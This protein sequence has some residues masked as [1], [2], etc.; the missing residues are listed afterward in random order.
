[1]KSKYILPIVLLLFNCASSQFYH[2]TQGK[3]D[4][5]NSGQVTYTLPIALPASIQSVGPTINITYSSGQPSGIAGPGWNISTI[6]SIARIST[7]KDIDGFIDGV[8]FDDND[9][10]ALDGQRLLIKPTTGNY[11]QDGAEYETEV[12]S[13]TKIQQFGSGDNIYFIVTSPD[14][15]RSWYGKYN[16]VLGKDI[17]AYYI[18]HYEDSKGNFIDYNYSNPYDGGSIRILNIKFG[19]NIYSN[20]TAINRI[21]FIY[22]GIDRAEKAYIKGLLHTK[23]VLLVGIEVFTNDLLFKAYEI[24]HETDQLNHQRIVSIQEYNSNYEYANPI[25]FEYNKTSPGITLKPNSLAWGDEIDINENILLT[26]DFMGDGSIGY[27]QNNR[28][29]RSLLDDC[30]TCNGIELPFTAN[31]RKTVLATSIIEGKLASQQLIVNFDE[32]INGLSINVFNSK[33]PSTSYHKHIDFDNS[34]NCEDTCNPPLEDE[35][36]GFQPNPNNKCLSPTYNKSSNNYL[37]G[38]FNGDGISEV[39]VFSFNEVR[40]FEVYEGNLTLDPI[41]NL[42]DPEDPNNNPNVLP[43]STTCH[44]RVYKTTL[45][46]VRL[47]DLNPNSPVE[48]GSYGNVALTN[49]TYLEGKNKYVGDFNGDGKSDVFVV[50][51]NGSYKVVTFNQLNV[52]PWVTLEILGSGLISEYNVT[53]QLFLGDFNGDSKTDLMLPNFSGNNC[54]GQEGN[55]E[56]SKWFIFYSNPVPNSNVH[57]FV[58]AE[59]YITTYLPFDQYPNS[60]QTFRNMYFAVDSN[61]DGKT[62][63]VKV[64]IWYHDVGTFWTGA[65]WRYEYRIYNYSNLGTHFA[66]DVATDWKDCQANVIPMVTSVKNKGKGKTYDLVVLNCREW[67]P[68]FEG[69]FYKYVHHYSFDKNYLKD[70]TIKKITSG[71][72]FIV[73]E[74]AYAPME[75]ST[76]GDS[77]YTY[78]QALEYPYVEIAKLPNSYLLKQYRNTTLGVTK[79]QD[80]KYHNL[81]AKLDGLGIIGFSKTARSSFYVPGLGDKTWSITTNDPRK[82]GATIKTEIKKRPQNENFNI[83]IINS[84]ISQTDNLYTENLDQNSHRY[85]ILLNK[86]TVRDFISGLKNEKIYE[87]YTQD[88][89]LPKIVTVKNYHNDVLQGTTT[90][91]TSYESST[92]GVGYNYYIGRPT[93]TETTIQAYGD[94]KTKSEKLFYTNGNLTRVEKKSNNDPVTMVETMTYYSNGNL[95]SKTISAEGTSPV[96]YVEPRT[97]Q[98]KYDPTNR[99]INDIVDAQGLEIKYEDFHPIYGLPRK[100]INPYGLITTSTYDHWGKKTQVTD[101]LGKTVNYHY[102]KSNGQAITTETV[103]Y[104]AEGISSSTVI[105]DVLGRV[106]KKGTTDINGQWSFVNTKYDQLGRKSSESEPY[107]TSPSL[108]NDT[109]YDNFDRPILIKSYTGKETTITYEELTVTSNDGMLTKSVT[110]NGNGHVISTI[111]EP[112][113]SIVHS[114]YA[115]GNL[116]ESIYENTSIQFFYDNWGRKIKI[117]DPSAGIIETTYNAFGEVKTET[118]PKGTTTFDYDDFGKVI[119]KT[120]TGATSSENTSMTTIYHYNTDNQLLENIEV[121]NSFDGDSSYLY[122][123]DN[124]YRVKKIKENVGEA[125]FEKTYE[126]D[127]FGRIESEENKG[128]VAGK[129]AGS[130]IKYFYKNGLLW[131]IADLSNNQSLW[132]LNEVNA[133]GQIKEALFGN[134]V[135]IKNDYDNLGYLTKAT[136]EISSNPEDLIMQLETNFEHVTGNLLGRYTSLFD[137]NENFGYD[138]LDRLTSET[139]DTSTVL[140]DATFDNDI[141]GFEYTGASSGYVTN[142]NEALKVKLTPEGSNTKKLIYENAVEGQVLSIKADTTLGN[143]GNAYVSVKIIEVDPVTQDILCSEFYPYMS[144]ETFNYS[145]TVANNNMN[146]FLLFQVDDYDI[147]S[148]PNILDPNTFI[149]DEYGNMVPPVMYAN[150]TLDNLIVKLVSSINASQDYD[151]KGRIS[152]HSAIGDYVY[153]DDVHPFQATEI[154]NI[155]GPANEYFANNHDINVTYNAFNSPIEIENQDKERIGFGYNFMEQRSAM[156]YGSLDVNRNDRPN[157]RYYS[158]ICNMEIDYS[159]PTDEVIFTIFVGGDAYTAPVVIKNDGTSASYFYLHRD[160]QGS[161]LAITN[162]VAKIVEK[163]LFDA[164]GNILKVQDADGNDLPGLMFFDRGYTGH[165]HIEGAGLINMNA[166]LYDPKVHRFLQADKYIQDPYNTQNYNRYSYCINNPLKYTDVTG[167]VFGADAAVLIGVGIALVMYFGNAIINQEPVYIDG[168]MSTV[169]FAG[170]SSALTFGIGEFATTITNFFVRSGFQALAH[171]MVQGSL[172]YI[173]GGDFWSGAAAGSISSIASSAWT[174]GGTSE[175]QGVGGKFADSG[176]GMIAFGTISGGVAAELTGGNFWQGA[177]SGFMVSAL[178][179]FAHRAFDDFE[180]EEP[181]PNR[182]NGQNIQKPNVEDM[183]PKYNIPK[184]TKWK[185]VSNRATIYTKKEIL[186]WSPEGEVEVYSRGAKKHLGGF[187]YNDRSKQTG[188]ADP[189]RKPN[190]GWKIQ[191]TNTSPKLKN[192]VNPKSTITDFTLFGPLMQWQL[193]DLMIETGH[194]NYYSGFN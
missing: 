166:R 80:F 113:G 124:F 41:S 48:L 18:V 164:W 161:I 96:N 134:G 32:L 46:E 71:G 36:G 12:Q 129:V 121:H 72:G 172:N 49:F 107:S 25:V 114:Y 89:F 180:Q 118:R 102:S 54:A 165:E 143:L 42:D 123:Y 116:K 62:D 141:E 170:F 83:Q 43:P 91:D 77:F 135:M 65:H 68:G 60:Q 10:L 178:N 131:K 87:Q 122:E 61:K 142:Q 21:D 130:N 75:V 40:K 57:M 174:G 97:T 73:D 52:A 101:Y 7:R 2:D 120:I 55:I 148:N 147:I 19:G 194:S 126:Y 28:V 69:L 5:T 153:G 47:I 58:R 160:Y 92:T 177:L 128:S 16:N 8:D 27:V 53:K 39:L 188:E 4:I 9:K 6:S 127:A 98:Y 70:N 108:W 109:F 104:G 44:W 86:Q 95:E 186:Q 150:F 157:R 190:G 34:A 3:L 105:T 144:S 88:Y 140:V 167:N 30:N 137:Y 168:V 20:P 1:M 56:C 81:V 192:I 111:D 14:G 136:H 139:I 45:K 24:L 145:Y 115:D 64:E 93:L 132:E 187:R 76:E 11:W 85:S 78:T 169:I 179:H 17:N 99:F 66:I 84:N 156:Y 155:Q 193:Q 158:S 181:D 189:G 38:D 51:Y 175:W 82:R 173:Q 29:F 74:F 90:S 100:E 182:K 112:G 33:S 110:K 163:R 15:A 149:S 151:D 184:G 106:V 50:D 185:T 59:H 79:I 103:S 125:N 146:V 26:G 159:I 37:E 191:N 23:N 162:E 171:G 117:K 138:A 94:T 152:S 119:Q 22:V 133:R 35:N 183:D 176:A 31:K 154:N 67:G 13:N 63:L